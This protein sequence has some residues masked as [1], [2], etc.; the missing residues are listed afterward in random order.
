MSDR[1]ALVRHG[2]PTEA[3]LRRTGRRLLVL[4]GVVL[5]GLAVLAAVGPWGSTLFVVA[6]FLLV[7][8][9]GLILGDVV[10]NHLARREIL[11][12]GGRRRRRRLRWAV[13]RGRTE[14]LDDDDR[15]TCRH[16]LPVLRAR[17]RLV[18]RLN[19][20]ALLG[21]TLVL[22]GFWLG[23]RPVPVWSTLLALVVLAV[24]LAELALRAVE[25]RAAAHALDVVRA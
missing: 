5:V 17:S 12:A 15:R 14:A 20:T 7:L 13:L 24:G 8:G 6:G 4:V 22:L 11:T 9:T 2:L 25:A 23:A 18:L 21:T 16:L 10:P 1:P 3:G 19:A